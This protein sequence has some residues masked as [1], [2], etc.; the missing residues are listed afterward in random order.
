MPI[1]TQEQLFELVL[2]N[3]KAIESMMAEGKAT[4]EHLEKAMEQTQ[5][6]ESWLDAQFRDKLDEIFKRT[7]DEK[8]D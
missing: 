6:M 4:Q 1:W 8:V 3:Y 5:H 7:Y 2:S